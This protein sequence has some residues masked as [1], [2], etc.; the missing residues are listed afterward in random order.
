MP[1][2]MWSEDDD[3][4]RNYKSLYTREQIEAQT[5]AQITQ[6]TKLGLIDRT[7]TQQEKTISLKAVRI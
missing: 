1:N 4:G 3:V 5:R 6:T 2:T 7:R